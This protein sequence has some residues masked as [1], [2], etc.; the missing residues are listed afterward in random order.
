MTAHDALFTLGGTRAGS[1]V[2]V[3][4]VGSGVGIAAVQLARAAQA[5]VF[6][7]ARTADKLARARDHGLEHAIGADAFDAQLAKIAPG[8]VDVILDFVGGPYLAG[9]IK[10]LAPR[11]ASYPHPPR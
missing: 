7:T 8:G 3:H 10:S 2:L 6:G 4:A 1:N 5:H 11:D 9:N